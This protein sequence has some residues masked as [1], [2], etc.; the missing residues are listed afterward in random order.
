MDPHYT[1]TPH[2]EEEEECVWLKLA[3]GCFVWMLV[4]GE[5]WV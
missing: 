5:H 3:A 1:K 4:G 2:H